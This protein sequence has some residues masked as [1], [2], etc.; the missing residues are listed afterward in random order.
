MAILTNL[1]PASSFP[2]LLNLPDVSGLTPVL[3]I[4]QDGF[5]NNSP[6][7]LS[8]TSFNIN[9]TMGGFSIDNVQLTAT[10]ADINAV[11]LDG[12][13]GGLTSALLLPSGTTAQRPLAPF[14]G[15]IRYNTTTSKI[16]AYANNIWQ[17]L[18]V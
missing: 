5:G 4:V 18:T 2:A 1:S 16:E 11:C 8:T 7:S 6:I 15:D 12:D 10:A 9:T 3:Q 17:N 13:F 14:N